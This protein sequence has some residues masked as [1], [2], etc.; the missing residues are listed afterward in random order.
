MYPCL[1]KIAFS[2][3]KTRKKLY[4][5]KKEIIFSLRFRRI[6]F[7]NRITCN[8]FTKVR[9]VDMFWCLIPVNPFV[10]H[11]FMFS[12]NVP[13]LRKL[14]RYDTYLHYTWSVIMRL[15]CYFQIFD[16]M[17][18][19]Y[20]NFEWEVFCVMLRINLEVQE[21]MKLM[22]DIWFSLACTTRQYNK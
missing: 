17:V 10:W 11:S 22:L 18:Y 3:S 12:Y 7:L 1:G 15:S 16:E 6:C 20:R 14:P 5:W 4:V 2:M 13:K 21:E 19:E 8:F 9:C